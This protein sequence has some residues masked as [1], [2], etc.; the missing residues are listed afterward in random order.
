MGRARK[1]GAG[2]VH[3]GGTDT[4]P[5]ASYDAGRRP[6]PA[7]VPHRHS[8]RG[9]G[10]LA[11]AY[12][13]VIGPA[14][15]DV[16]HNFVQ[17]WN[18]ASERTLDDGRRG[19]DAEDQLVFPTRLSD[20]RGKSVVQIQRNVHAGRYADGRASPGGAPYNIADGERTIFDQYLLAI[21]AAKEAIY[22]ENQAIPIPPVAD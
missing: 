3:S 15:T 22:I 1:R 8:P 4:S 9:S 19:H 14:A 6:G 11:D 17:R 16:H 2:G 10:A 18:E 21:G 13:E 12:V 20:P 7:A 5:P